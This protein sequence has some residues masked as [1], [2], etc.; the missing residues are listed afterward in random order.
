MPGKGQRMAVHLLR[1]PGPTLVASARYQSYR[2]KRCHRAPSYSAHERLRLPE[3]HPDHGGQTR[4]RSPETLAPTQ[5]NSP[6]PKS[7]HRR[8][9]YRRRGTTRTSCLT[10]ISRGCAFFPYTTFDNISVL[11]DALRRILGSAF[12]SGNVRGCPM[13][14][15]MQ[16]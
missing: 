11:L 7:G 1:L 14:V 2:I 15:T 12:F 6:A 16:T 8:P 3:R 9:I 5:R 10:V 4:A 13:V